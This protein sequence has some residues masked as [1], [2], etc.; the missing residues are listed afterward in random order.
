MKLE[1]GFILVLLVIVA[2]YQL[3]YLSKYTYQRSDIDGELYKVKNDA[4]A[5]ASANALA[6]INGRLVR[7][8]AYIRAS[9][10]QPVYV[11][12][13]DRFKTNS[14]SENV[15]DIDT[16]YTTDKES[17]TF[18]LTPRGHE[19]AVYPVNLLMYVAIHELAHV[20]SESTG[21]NE[22]F[23]QNFASLLDYAVEAG[24]YEFHNFKSTPVEYCGLMIDTI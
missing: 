13:L 10:Q 12:R 16:S 21:H 19:K 2:V 3:V 7:L 22:E 4:L 15:W 14:I 11:R 18:C 1:T 20:V 9:E 6:I 23:K 17:I 8:I 24:V 5:L